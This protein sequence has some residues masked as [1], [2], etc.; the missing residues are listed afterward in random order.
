MTQS[1]RLLEFIRTHP[2]C[3]IAEITRAM[4]PFIANPRARISD[5]RAADYVIACRKDPH[6]VDRY[7]VVERRPVTN[8]TQTE[9]FA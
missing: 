2:G 5:L 3:S 7:Y 4:D 9:A 8:G 6:G 1:D